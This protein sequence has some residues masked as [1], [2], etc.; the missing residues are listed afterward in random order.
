MTTEAY[1]ELDRELE[2]YL[3]SLLG[4]WEGTSRWYLHHAGGSL[5]FLQ[6]A[7]RRV[8]RRQGQERA[9]A[10]VAPKSSAHGSNQPESH[11]PEKPAEP[12]QPPGQGPKRVLQRS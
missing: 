2:Q 7:P 5:L 11:G 10:Q 9:A 4:G 8:C 1:A 3:R 12:K 6:R